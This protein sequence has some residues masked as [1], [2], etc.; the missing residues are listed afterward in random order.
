MKPIYSAL[1]TMLL[2]S[3]C[4]AQKSHNDLVQFMDEAR[5]VP[6]SKID[7]PPTFEP[8]EPFVY[9]VAEKRS[10][11]DQPQSADELS[12]ARQGNRQSVEP[13]FD[14]PKEPLE[15]FNLSGLKMVGTLA[16]EGSLWAL[17]DDGEGSI[18]RVQPGNYMGKNFGRITNATETQLELIEIVSD[19]REG[20]LERPK[21]IKLIGLD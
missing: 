19:G 16:R 2:L 13:D 20:W 10:P 15:F 8:Y 6:Q 17:V 11:F 1:I 7:P 4:G 9:A 5:K 14:R 3:G 18:H 12:L 21:T